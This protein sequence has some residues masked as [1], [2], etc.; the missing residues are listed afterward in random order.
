MD[1]L[2]E[3]IKDKQIDTTAD[4]WAED[5]KSPPLSTIIHIHNCNHNHSIPI[6]HFQC[7]PMDRQTNGR[8]KL[9]VHN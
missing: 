9:P 8:S 2:R 4:G 5:K 7:K 6:A 3:T 1:R